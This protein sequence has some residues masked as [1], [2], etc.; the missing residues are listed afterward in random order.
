MKIT[1]CNWCSD[2]NNP[3]PD[4]HIQSNEGEHRIYPMYD[5]P[6][7]RALSEEFQSGIEDYPYSSDKF[8]DWL[9]KRDKE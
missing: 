4:H 8:L 3:S 9:E 6:T 1:F 5:L 2:P 7:L